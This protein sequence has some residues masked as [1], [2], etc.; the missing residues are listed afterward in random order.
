LSK[1]I[2]TAGV[3]E[4]PTGRFLCANLLVCLIRM[5]RS[6]TSMNDSKI[7]V[8]SASKK[9]LDEKDC[10]GIWSAFQINCR[11]PTLERLPI[12]LSQKD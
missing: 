3:D 12:S 4:N 7:G 5:M 11:I 2:G 10:R 9:G 8:E 1:V 6:R